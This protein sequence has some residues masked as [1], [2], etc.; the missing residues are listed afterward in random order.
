MRPPVA[1]LLPACTLLALAWLPGPLHSEQETE[2]LRERLFTQREA[3][4][5]ERFRR[6]LE[7]NPGEDSLIDRL[8]AFYKDNPAPLLAVYR[9]EAT[10]GKPG[11]A[12]VLGKLYVRLGDAAEAAAAFL[13]ATRQDPQNWQAWV[14]LAEAHRLAGDP[15]SEQGALKE[16]LE[17]L[18]TDHSARLDLILR[19]AKGLLNAGQKEEAREVLS[20]IPPDRWGASA[21]E[22][23]RLFSMSG[24]TENAVAL[25]RVAA[26]Q[27]G[28]GQLLDATRRLLE[29]LVATDRREAFL[30]EATKAIDRVAPGSW[31]F[32]E[33]GN[34]I[35][36]MATAKGTAWVEQLERAWTA[37]P[38]AEQIPPRILWR[39]ALLAAA[40]GDSGEE[41][42]VLTE[43]M[44]L[45]PRDPALAQRLIHLHE[46]RGDPEA[47][48]GLLEQ[49][50]SQTAS[51]TEWV[52]SSARLLIMASR[53]QE[54]ME[55]L[56]M[57]IESN[58]KDRNLQR[59]IVALLKENR[60]WAEARR[61]LE[62]QVDR[63][64]AEAADVEALAGILIDQSAFDQAASVLNAWA[65]KAGNDRERAHRL[66]SG[67]ELLA[68][69]SRHE[70]AAELLQRALPHVEDESEA[71]MR[72]AA[73]F[74]A[75]G[76]LERARLELLA[77]GRAAATPAQQLTVDRQL[78]ALLNR[79]P[80][81]SG[82]EETF[83]RLEVPGF[84]SLPI[85]RLREGGEN[86]TS[87]VVE[88]AASFRAEAGAE[89]SATA[90]LRAAEWM[91]LMRDH[92]RALQA[93]DEA[94]KAEPGGL[95][96]PQRGAALAAEAGQHDRAIAYLRL[97]IQNGGDTFP[98][99][100]RIARLLAETGRLDEA[101]SLLNAQLEAGAP[102]IETLTELSAIQ[103]R[104]GFNSD[105]LTAL[106]RIA[107][108]A[109]SGQRTD[110]FL[111]L[112]RAHE[113]LGEP[114]DGIE[115]LLSEAAKALDA[116]HR[117]RLLNEIVDLTERHNLSPWTSAR[118]RDLQSAAPQNTFYAQT[119][120]RLAEKAG[121]TEDAL[122][123]LSPSGRSPN[124]RSPAEWDRLISLAFETGDSA[125][126]LRLARLAASQPGGEAAAAGLRVAR[127]LEETLQLSEARLEYDRLVVRFARDPAVQKAAAEF[128]RLLNIPE[129]RLKA[130]RQTTVLDP[131]DPTPWMQLGETLVEI[132]KP[133]E[134]VEPL[135]KVLELIDPKTEAE[136]FLSPLPRPSTL[137]GSLQILAV[138]GEEGLTRA[139][140][141]VLRG[142][143]ESAAQPAGRPRTPLGLRLEV[144]RLLTSL[145]REN[146]ETS[147]DATEAIKIHLNK[148]T[149]WRGALHSAWFSNRQEEA[150]EILA[151][152]LQGTPAGGELAQNFLWLCVVTG[153]ADRLAAW[154]AREPDP[155][156]Q[157]MLLKIAFASHLG[158][159]GS[160]DTDFIGRL[161]AGREENPSL[162][163]QLARIAGRSNDPFLAAWLLEKLW[164][165]DET[166]REQ[167]TDA[168]EAATWLCIAGKHDLTIQ[169]LH[170]A[171]AEGGSSRIADA[172]QALRL[173]YLLTPD[174]DRA[175]LKTFVLEEA[176]PSAR[177]LLLYVLDALQNEEAAAPEG[178]ALVDQF[179]TALLLRSW[180]RTKHA[181]ALLR[182]TLRSSLLETLDGQDPHGVE[183]QCRLTLAAWEVEA[184][185]PA[186]RAELLD[187]M[188]RGG[189][190]DTFLQNLG[191]HL[192]NEGSASAAAD[193]FAALG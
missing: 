9:E 69:A 147:P 101:V 28:P 42:R 167:V 183:E 8:W 72:L 17:V 188:I 12:L 153:N 35:H 32:T 108:I 119:L 130:L 109:P 78:F 81:A 148:E 102:E 107:A 152:H 125:Q 157:R 134:A 171:V 84:G 138:A 168:V 136:T 186:K 20:L 25:L 29:L 177:P 53:E 111:N 88:M 27:S 151:A 87:A 98:L 154:I 174:P 124:V 34:T 173:R 172:V 133:A 170:R 62:R 185:P 179:E 75:Q 116:Q 94:I 24:A 110:A 126:A 178:A 65:D 156:V 163:W 118:L 16:A 121:R 146:L 155:G 160:G 189:A 52:I 26:E 89:G 113:R 66:L 38:D 184:V 57:L 158:F 22:A 63:D 128:Y 56:E 21:G 120:S 123:L 61:I 144:A 141:D 91:A 137:V 82:D 15:A 190:N 175:D 112:A 83:A 132:G 104:S 135:I 4:M 36:A 37:S 14:A 70:A 54:A 150:L 169:V 103:Q 191:S 149:D 45:R 18:P 71:R 127:L 23:A 49:F 92:E 55:R 13:L 11:S 74:E 33:L 67:A 6:A 68:Q 140:A 193:V 40:K 39:R 79:A 117:D 93:V 7:R 44:R 95:A 105:A 182:N 143:R 115:V 73:M 41:T 48:L 164:A 86:T 31:A 30:A 181:I 60:L 97:A 159:K 165:A 129:P 99:H 166:A 142:L 64:D 192:E 3:T 51:D 145:A 50:R 161:L 139:Q 10:S 59:R 100:R 85:R 114:R 19:L 2:P 131:R 47:A 77:A 80:A 5:I 180:N 76:L 176:A 1:W 122:T 187:S 106:Q 43:L 46:V 90:W 162:L 58:P 96:A